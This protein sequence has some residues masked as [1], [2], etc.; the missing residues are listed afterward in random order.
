MAKLKRGMAR[1]ILC[2][3]PTARC[4]KIQTGINTANVSKRKSPVSYC[5]I[6][7]AWETGSG[8]FCPVNKRSRIA[9]SRMGF[10][11]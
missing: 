7:V 10:G 5:D 1:H 4:K 9:W 11:K 6:K 8:V 2:I 3:V